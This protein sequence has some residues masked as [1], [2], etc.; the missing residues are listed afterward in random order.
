[1]T[2]NAMGAVRTKIK[3]PNAVDEELVA[4]GLLAPRLL[5]TCEVD[6][7]VNTGSVRLFG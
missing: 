1:M 2:T 7:L 4:R 5:R 6:A 3:L